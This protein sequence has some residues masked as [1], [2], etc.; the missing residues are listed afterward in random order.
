[1]Y[2]NRW[3]ADRGLG[4]RLLTHNVYITYPWYEDLV[5]SCQW[6]DTHSMDISIHSLLRYLLGGLHRDKKVL[7]WKCACPH[8]HIYVVS[9]PGLNGLRPGNQ[10]R[11]LSWLTVKSGPMSTSKPRSVNPEAM[12]LYPLSWPSSPTFATRILGRRPSFPSNSY[13]LQW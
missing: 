12:T 13:I 10:T 3:E 9:F 11:L 5:A 6:A 4:A 8:Y 1:M 7:T 2:C